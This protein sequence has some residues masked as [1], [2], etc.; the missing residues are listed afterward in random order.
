MENPWKFVT[1]GTKL[2]FI[3]QEREVT[4]QTVSIGELFKKFCSTSSIHGTYF[5]YESRSWSS[6][7]I[8]GLI[9]LV[10]MTLA[11]LFIYKHNL[12]WQAHPVVTSVKQI[13]IGEVHFPAITICPRD[14][15]RYVA[16]Q[17][18]LVI[19]GPK[20]H[21]T[22]KKLYNKSKQHLKFS[23]LILLS[24]NLTSIGKK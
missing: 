11:A 13:P 14:H 5:W 10:G 20:Y 6:K 16:I 2:S 4:P 8:W 18:D 22:I 24:K 7:I 19:L 21:C 3:F 23:G 15:T 9:V 1:F 12:S 17:S